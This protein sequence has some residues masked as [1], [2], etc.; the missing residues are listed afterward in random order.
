[1]FAAESGPFQYHTHDY[2]QYI[3]GIVW[4]VRTVGLHPAHLHLFLWPCTTVSNPSIICGISLGHTS[5]SSQVQT[6]PPPPL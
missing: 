3:E 2:V 6:R 1:M 5:T 4:L